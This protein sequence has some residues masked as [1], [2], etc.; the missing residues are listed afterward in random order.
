MEEDSGGDEL[1][2]PVVEHTQNRN[3]DQ[4]LRPAQQDSA[5]YRGKFHPR[6]RSS[7]LP[8]RA[9]AGCTSQRVG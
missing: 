1:S 6:P 3:V 8:F 9:S 4:I 7:H 5:G 2:R